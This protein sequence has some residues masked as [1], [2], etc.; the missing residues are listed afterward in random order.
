MSTAT[1]TADQRR[2]KVLQPG[3]AMRFSLDVMDG[4][5][6][7]RAFVTDNRGPS[8]SEIADAY[9]AMVADLHNPKRK[10][11][12]DEPAPIADADPVAAAYDAMV[13]DLTRD[14]R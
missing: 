7:R 4:A 8:Q 14:R 12:D 13:A 9:D 1:L 3:E 11:A 10:A 6:P 5:A 2:R